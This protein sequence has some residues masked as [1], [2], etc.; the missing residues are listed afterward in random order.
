MGLNGCERVEFDPLALKEQMRR[1]E[2]NILEFARS[3]KVGR[4]CVGEMSG[5]GGRVEVNRGDGEL[6]G[7]KSCVWKF[8]LHSFQCW[9]KC[10]EGGAGCVG[11]LNMVGLLIL[12]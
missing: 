11:K 10:I 9:Y 8:V 12:G 1:G 7:G 2:S 4:G 5:M 6:R 3:C